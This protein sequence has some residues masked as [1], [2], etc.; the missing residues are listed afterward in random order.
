MANPPVRNGVER[1]AALGGGAPVRGQERRSASRIMLVASVEAEEITNGIRRSARTSDVSVDGCYLDA[2]NP[3]SPGTRIRLDLTKGNET[4][5]LLDVVTCAHQHMG[6]GVSFMELRPGAREIVQSWIAE[7]ESGKARPAPSSSAQ[8]PA[9]GIPKD[10]RTAL[11]VERLVQILVKKGLLPQ[12]E[13]FK[14]E[15]GHQI[16]SPSKHTPHATLS[17]ELRCGRWAVSLRATSS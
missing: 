12:S 10:R 11:R 14:L 2:I 17:Q 5:H 7:S 16:G 9:T 8:I 1:T 15:L 3:S 6:M 13:H 4:R